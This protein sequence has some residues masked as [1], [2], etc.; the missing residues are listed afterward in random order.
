MAVPGGAGR[1]WTRPESARRAPE[2]RPPSS[3][4]ALEGESAPGYTSPQNAHSPSHGA[5]NYSSSARKRQREKKRERETGEPREQA[6]ASKE[7]TAPAPSITYLELL[8]VQ[9]C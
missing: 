2:S 5:T 6:S 9:V 3:S 4:S 1:E 7:G 8:N